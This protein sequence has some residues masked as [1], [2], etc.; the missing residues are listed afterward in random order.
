MDDN[1]AK[2]REDQARAD[3]KAARQPSGTMRFNKD[4]QIVDVMEDDFMGTASLEPGQRRRSS[5]LAREGSGVTTITPGS[6]AKRTTSAGT[7]IRS[8]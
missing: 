3:D 8:R 2:A 5:P 1:K 6:V 4:G 7:I